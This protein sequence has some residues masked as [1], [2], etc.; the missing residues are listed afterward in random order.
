MRILSYIDQIACEKGR[1]V[2]YVIF[3]EDECPNNDCTKLREKIRKW[4]AENNNRVEECFP[5]PNDFIMLEGS[6][7]VL[8][9][10]IPYDENSPEFI[11]INNYLEYPNGSSR[12]AGVQFILL[13]LEETMK[14]KHHD[15]P[16]F[17]ESQVCKNMENT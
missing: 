10:D 17:G 13:R 1:D 16:G 2:L 11:K 14:N 6:N 4:F 3:N 15:E 9:L 7:T 5:A 8:Y 12:F